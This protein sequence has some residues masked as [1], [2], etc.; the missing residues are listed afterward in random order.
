MGSFDYVT[1]AR[2]V[3][4][5]KRKD[6]RTVFDRES[7]DDAQDESEHSYFLKYKSL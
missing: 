4:E 5:H 2:I 3:K 6:C 7:E 1:G